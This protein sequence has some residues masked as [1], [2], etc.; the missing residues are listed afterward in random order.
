MTIHSAPARAPTQAAEGLPRR[1]WT[2]DEIKAMVRAGIIAET[3]RIELIGGEVVTM[4]PKGNRHELVKHAL[5]E[6]WVPR[7]VGTQTTLITE[8]TLWISDK[9]FIEPDFV[10]WPRSVR[11]A[12][13][14]PDGIDLIVEIADTSLAYDTGRKAALYA[15]FGLREY[16]VIDATALT[17]RIHRIPDGA[18]FTSIAE[19]AGDIVVTPSTHPGLAVQLAALEIE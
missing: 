3:E 10:F 11:L 7:V 9:N 12:D 15:G 14:K 18:A 13:L 19:Y 17:T 8:T 16:W 6:F 2:A 5:Q 1:A 4:S